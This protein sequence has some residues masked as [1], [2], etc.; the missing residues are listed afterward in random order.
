[1]IR[2]P[3]SVEAGRID[4]SSD[5][6]FCGVVFCPLEEEEE[7]P[8]CSFCEEEEESTGSCEGS[9]SV[10]SCEWSGLSAGGALPE[11]APVDGVSSGSTTSVLEVEYRPEKGVC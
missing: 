9:K 1:M 3:L 5:E 11:D 6:A 8:C 2:P 7:D 10:S 4:A